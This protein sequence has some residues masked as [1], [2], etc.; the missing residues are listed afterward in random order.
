MDWEE[1]DKTILTPFKDGGDEASEYCHDVN[2]F[3]YTQI[4]SIA[5][6]AFEAGVASQQ[7]NAADK[8]KSCNYCGDNG[9]TTG[10]GGRKPCPHCR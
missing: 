8:R 9:Y 3:N 10:K 5:I 7:I 1:F 2:V 6:R 4:R